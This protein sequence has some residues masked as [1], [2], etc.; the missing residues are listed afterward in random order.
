[1]IISNKHITDGLAWVGKCIHSPEQRLILGATALA[2]QP[3]IDL[4][5]KNVDEETR[6]TSV[7]RTL[8]KIV[9][10]TIVGVA[11]RAGC[12]ALVKKYC[13]YDMRYLDKGEKLVKRIVPKKKNGFFVPILNSKILGGKEK[14]FSLTEAEV[15]KRFEKYIKSMGTFVAT[16]AMIG[17]NFLIDAPLTKRLTSVFINKIN[18]NDNAHQKEVKR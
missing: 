3:V 9:A 7:A 1:M 14:N 4:C 11:V 16:I 6:K 18:K 2:T 5:N 13:K 12:I 17:T 15:Q 10:G 8:A